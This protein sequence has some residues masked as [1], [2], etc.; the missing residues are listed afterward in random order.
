[1]I[2]FTAKNNETQRV[3]EMTNEEL[4]FNYDLFLKKLIKYY[5][6]EGYFFEDLYQ[7]A[8]LELFKRKELFNAELGVFFC[9]YCKP[10]IIQK[11]KK[12]LAF[13]TNTVSI[14]S[15]IAQRENL[16]FIPLDEF[17]DFIGDNREDPL[18]EKEVRTEQDKKT[19]NQL[20]QLKNAINNSE[21]S[22]DTK[23]K[24]LKYIENIKTT[25]NFTYMSSRPE[26]KILQSL[27]DNKS[28]HS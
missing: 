17:E 1:M 20:K 24:L 2:Q 5:D 13:L 4:L 14:G 16:S 22:T 15:P 28:T 9:V 18:I 8:T 10:Y 23:N 25:L 12:E 26:L 6:R 21:F 27:I 7:V 11:I 3:K 19:K